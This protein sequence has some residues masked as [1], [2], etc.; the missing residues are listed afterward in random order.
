VVRSEMPEVPASRLFGIDSGEPSVT[1]RYA[2]AADRR[3]EKPV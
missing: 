1:K 3:R 2:F